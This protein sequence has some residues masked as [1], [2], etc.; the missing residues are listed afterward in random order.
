VY[1]WRREAGLLMDHP[2]ALIERAVDGEI[3]SSAFAATFSPSPLT[4]PAEY[5]RLMAL[6]FRP[7]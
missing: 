7:D 1:E 3:G 5:D 4:Q 6:G 2:Y